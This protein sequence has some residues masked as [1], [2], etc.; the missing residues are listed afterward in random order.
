[1]QFFP[2]A[3]RRWRKINVLLLVAT[4]LPPGDTIELH[5]IALMIERKTSISNRF[6]ASWVFLAGAAIAALCLLGLGLVFVLGGLE[7]R[8]WL[9]APG[10][11][12]HI[13]ALLMPYIISMIGFAWLL[14]VLEGVLSGQLFWGRG[15]GASNR[16]RG[17]I[18]FWLG[19]IFQSALCLN[20]IG[21]GIAL[22]LRWIT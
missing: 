3:T 17:P 9:I 19:V 21:L 22:K 10:T 13:G 2:Q 7:R 6:G 14:M 16:H 1:M 8:H 12:K 11:A 18:G 15:T 20:L 4:S 5:D